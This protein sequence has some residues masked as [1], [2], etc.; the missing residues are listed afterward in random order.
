MRVLLVS[1]VALFTPVLALAHEHG[2]PPAAAATSAHSTA[3]YSAEE[4]AAGLREGK[5]MGLAMPAEGNGYPGPRH[6][7]ELADQ[8]NLTPDQRRRT[9]ALFDDMRTDAS[10]LGEQLLTQEA[11]LY[12]IFRERRANAGLLESTARRI[13]E[14]EAL[15]KVAHLRAHLAMMEILSPA[16]VRQYVQLRQ[17][18]AGSGLTRPDAES[19]SQ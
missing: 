3:G 17:S 14:T 9:Q 2:A 6:V 8:L 10:R 15:L 1:A 4:R 5:G 13:G 11:E 7:L 19:H 16:Q 18:G 12:A